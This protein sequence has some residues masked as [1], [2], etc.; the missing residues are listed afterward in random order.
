MA[1]YP[2]LRTARIILSMLISLADLF[3]QISSQHCWEDCSHTINPVQ[4]LFVHKYSPSQVDIQSELEDKT[5]N[6]LAKFKRFQKNPNLEFLYALITLPQHPSGMGLL[7]HGNKAHRVCVSL[8]PLSHL[9]T[10]QPG[11]VPTPVAIHQIW[12]LLID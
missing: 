5:V 2:V 9:Q 6:K 7:G 4:R 10:K 12:R 11:S 3:D 8:L 1:L